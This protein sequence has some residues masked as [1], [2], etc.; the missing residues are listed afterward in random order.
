MNLPSNPNR[1]RF[2]QAG[3]GAAGGLLL[4][5]H[6]P[7]AGAAA[8]ARRFEPNAF[9]AIDGAGLV[10]LTMSFAEM[11]QGVYTSV[12]ML[13]AEELDIDLAQ[14]KLEHAPADERRYAHPT[15]RMQLTGGS[16]T[17]RSAWLPMRQAG[18]A[19]RMMLVAAAAEQWKVPAASCQAR[20]G[21]V[22]HLPSGRVLGYGA[23]AAHAARQPVPAEIVLK[24][25]AAFTLIGKPVHRLDAAAKSDGSATFG[26]DVQLPGMKVAAV[27]ACPVFGG[28]LAA[29]DGA[30]A[31][32]V[33]GVR[34]IVQLDDAVAVIA[35]HYGAA[36]KGLAA[37]SIQWDEGA[38]AA[39]SSGEWLRQLEQAGKAPGRVA[40]SSGDFQ[41]Q[42]QGGARR[43]DAV[44]HAPLLAHATMEPMNCTAL[45]RQGRAEIWTGSQAPARVQ[46][47]VAQALKL[48]PAAVTV[49]NHYMGGGFGRRLEADYA[50]QAALV[51]RHVDYPVKLVWSREEDMQH[52][53]YRPYFRDEMAATLDAAGAVTGLSHRVIGSSVRARYAPAWLK[54][55]LD[56]DAVAAAE[57]V[58]DIAHKHV[59]Y[60]AHESP[61]PSG[62][63]RGVG[64][65]HNTF[66]TESFI[67]ELAHAAG[68]DPLRYRLAML[69]KQPRAR[70]ALVL[71]ADKAGWGRKTAPGTGLGLAV[72]SWW[73]SAAACVVECAVGQDGAVSLKRVVMALDCG[74]A[75][76]PDGVVAQMEG[77]AIYALSAALYGRLTVENGRIAQSNF[78]D[79]PVL[80]MNEMPLFE[81]HLIPSGE[82]PGG[83]GEVGTA[84]L[85][86]ALANA[87]FAAS[88]KRTRT[89]PVT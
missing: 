14:V 7:L 45:V 88:G 82:P 62:F 2:L 64:P 44:Y 56:T 28:R 18:A 20:N 75:V 19:A 72:M 15:Y 26:I 42:L 13:I 52:G 43:I 79:Y 41:G 8:S 73:G 11:G 38:H 77:G 10:T 65:T 22:R 74:L 1:R 29:V 49:H 51:A 36:R 80:R 83:V 48:E 33:N 87:V 68:A 71:A 39:F 16:S 50:V 46:A 23:L 76:N 89:L 57:S 21:E 24:P 86:P 59:D 9:I 12:P 3:A 5:L 66:V 84:V 32:A 31:L 60:C 35:D 34:Q 85:G 53:M 81:T 67:D 47:L 63:W 25:N 37:L 4:S 30:R 55:G 40:L 17:V 61:V 6:L 69:G 54:D 58:Y 70:A 27:A 78:H